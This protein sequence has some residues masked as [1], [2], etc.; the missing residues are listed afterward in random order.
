MEFKEI[1]NGV[2]IPAI[3]IGTWGMEF[4]D[5][6]KVQRDIKSIKESIKLGM[7]H[8]DTA[9]TY[10]AGETEKI[11]GKTIRDIDRSRIFITTKVNKKHLYY[12]DVINS[13]KKSLQRM[14]ID[15][16]DL[17][18]IHSPNPK[19]P[20]KETMKAMDY[21]VEKKIIKFIG[22]GNFSKKLLEK[23]QSY[24]KNKIIANQVEYNLIRR[25]PERSLLKYCQNKGILLIAHRPLA[26]GKLAKIKVKILDEL[27]L[28][29][30][31]T[32]AQIA[33]N[34]L[35]AK[36][37]VIVIPKSS[38]IR[39]IKENSKSV[40]WRLDEKDEKKLNKYFLKRYLFLNFVSTLAEFLKHFAR[41]ILS[42]K[43]TEKMEK[44][45]GKI[46]MGLRI[47]MQSKNSEKLV[48]T[49]LF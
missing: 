40:G 33:I 36:P 26:Q 45:Y 37:N 20:L 9:E 35:I 13:A 47:N 10:G 29:Y 17:Y 4:S 19:I 16:I 22:V 24:T 39:H 12:K 32:S 11:V 5:K 48:K 21:L 46:L 27:C 38:S 8:I 28:K 41:N 25:L 30:K 23:A 34:W 42:E 49:H 2:K 6:K 15:Y 14:G 1:K 31:K 3:G 44:N 18:I 7:S 43:T